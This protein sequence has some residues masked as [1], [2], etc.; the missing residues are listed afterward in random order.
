MKHVYISLSIDANIDDDMNAESVE[1]NID[2]IIPDSFISKI[3][4][5]YMEEYEI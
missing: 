4:V 1:D 3:D 5:E 2:V